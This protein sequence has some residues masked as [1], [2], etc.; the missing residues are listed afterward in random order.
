VSKNDQLVGP[1]RGKQ[2]QL[3]WI[4]EVEMPKLVSGQPMH[5]RE[6][7]GIIDKESDDRGT[8]RFSV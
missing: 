1:V 5:I 3:N 7:I 6:D 4:T 2:Q 8:E